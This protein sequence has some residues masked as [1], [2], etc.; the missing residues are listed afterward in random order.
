MN[1]QILVNK[2]ST[3]SAVVLSDAGAGFDRGALKQ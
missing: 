2:K 1:S 3:Y